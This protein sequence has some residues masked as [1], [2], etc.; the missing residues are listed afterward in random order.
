MKPWFHCAKCAHDFDVTPAN[1]S[2]GDWCP[3]CSGR[4]RCD[5]PECT[6][7]EKTCDVCKSKKAKTQTRITRTWVCVGCLADAVLRDPKEQPDIVQRAKVSLEILMLAELIRQSVNQDAS[8]ICKP[9]S[10]DCPIFPGLGYKP[11]C[12]WCFTETD[13]LIVLGRAEQLNLHII[14]NAVQLEIIEESRAIHTAQRDISDEDREV[15]IRGLFSGE[16]VPLGVLYVT[17]AHDKHRDAHQDDVFFT[18]EGNEYQV[19]SHKMDAWMARI[20]EVRDTLVK[21]VRERSNE[22]L[23]IGH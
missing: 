3:F 18:K 16:H 22:T 20:R 15:D 6:N 13:E 12:I 2:N 17:A 11:D 14:R 5:K 8:F 4:Q 19:M 9:T 23:Y 21:M 1:I 10:W 7:C